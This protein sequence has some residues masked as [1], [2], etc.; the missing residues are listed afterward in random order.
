MYLYY[1]CIYKHM[2]KKRIVT[3]VDEDVYAE[4]IALA[5]R[6]LRIQRGALSIALQEA[7]KLWIERNR[8]EKV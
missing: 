2:G 3:L 7:M 4:F 8:E 6:K 5:T 1:I